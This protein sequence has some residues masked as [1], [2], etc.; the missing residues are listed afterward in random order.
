MTNYTKH[1]MELLEQ[2]SNSP[3]KQASFLAFDQKIIVRTKSGAKAA[4]EILAIEL[5][6]PR[7]YKNN[8]ITCRYVNAKQEFNLQEGEIHKHLIGWI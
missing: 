6:R 7:N 4:I 5:A 8:R 1:W 3:R 2:I